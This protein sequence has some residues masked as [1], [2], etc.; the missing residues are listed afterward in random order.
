VLDLD[1]MLDKC[2]REQWKLDDLDWSVRPKSLARDDE[3]AVVQYFTDMAGIER[4]AKALFEEQRR[5]ATD[6]TLQKIFSTFVVDEERHA[7]AAERLAAHYDVHHHRDYAQTPALVRFTPHFLHAIRQFSAEVAN[8]Y[9]TTGELLLDVALLRSLDDYVDDDMSRQAMRLINRD[10]SRHIAVDYHM[11][12]YYASGAYQDWLARQPRRP[13]RAHAGAWWAFLNMLYFAGPFVKAVFIE[14]MRMTDPSGRRIKEAFKRAQLLGKKPDVAARPFT[15]FVVAIQRVYENP[16][17]QPIVG[18]FAAR[19][20]GLPP[21]VLVTLHTD[22]EA[23]RAMHM[24]Y[25]A[26]AEEALAAKYAG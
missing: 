4:L 20:A 13:L 23:R 6:P 18:R 5:R 12:E 24:S 21:E 25:E 22:E 7:Q 16:A 17:L 26:L 14:P 1:R 2:V 8:V 15:R 11:A 3:I 10:E 19:L 9:I